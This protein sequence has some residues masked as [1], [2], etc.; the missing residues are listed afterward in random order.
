M[1][2]VKQLKFHWVDEI[3]S[4]KEYAVL[5]KTSIW[6]LVFE[7]CYLEVEALWLKPGC[8]FSSSNSY[9]L[10]TY[11]NGRKIQEHE[12]GIYSQLKGKPTNSELNC[13]HIKQTGSNPRPLNKFDRFSS[14]WCSNQF[15]LRDWICPKLINHALSV[16][17]GGSSLCP[18]RY[19]PLTLKL[20]KN[21]I[22][23]VKLCSTEKCKCYKHI[24]LNHVLDEIKCLARSRGYKLGTFYEK[25]INQR[26]LQVGYL[27][28][29]AHQSTA[30][31]RQQLTGPHGIVPI[32]GIMDS[33]KWGWLIFS[34]R[35]LFTKT[36]VR[37]THLF[38]ALVGF[39]DFAQQPS[40]SLVS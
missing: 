39:K 37:Q 5:D 24:L 11:L 33:T 29:K 38:H 25:H 7:L 30:V 32:V 3:F 9:S 35:F 18:T 15:S 20:M 19:L 27:V 21:W 10:C 8:S 12:K 6:I 28:W 34:L 16:V 14:G 36:E 4:I 2:E 22:L 23:S 31:E 13:K 26:W 17:R 1:W 40:L